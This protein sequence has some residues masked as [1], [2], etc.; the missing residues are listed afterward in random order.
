MKKILI[1][2]RGIIKDTNP[3]PLPKR[4]S[5]DNRIIQ[6]CK[7]L[8]TSISLPKL[9]KKHLIKALKRQKLYHPVMS[10]SCKNRISSYLL[11]VYRS[12]FSG[13]EKFFSSMIHIKITSSQSHR[14]AVQS[15]RTRPLLILPLGI[16]SLSTKKPLK[17][18]TTQCHF[19]LNGTFR[20]STP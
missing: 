14:R 2:P 16:P 20:R 19:S 12:A 18:S 15:E 11:P 4:K 7:L 1:I 13:T 10:T 17:A 9:W 6:L 8:R 3:H 5:N